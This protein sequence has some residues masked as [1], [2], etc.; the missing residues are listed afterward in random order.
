MQN[1]DND[2]V[3]ESADHR[4]RLST[5]ATLVGAPDRET[6]LLELEKT[7]GDYDTRHLVDESTWTTQLAA[8]LSEMVNLR[9]THVETWISVNLQRFKTTN[10]NVEVLQREMASATIDMQASVELCKMSCSRCHLLCT[11][12]RRHD[13]LLR[14]HDCNTNHL[15]LRSCEFLD[16]HLGELKPCHSA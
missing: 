10:A 3:V 12:S 13:P 2:T 5:S 6:L 4:Y 7:W 11:L 15:C 14:P 8:Y 9:I 16:D 1:I